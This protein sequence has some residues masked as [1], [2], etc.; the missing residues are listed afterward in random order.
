MIEVLFGESEAGAM[1]MAVRKYPGKLGKDVICLAFLLDIGNIQEAVDST[2]RKKLIFTL[3]N[4]EQWGKDSEMEASLQKAGNVYQK[5]LSRLKQYLQNGEPIRI[6]YSECPYSLCGFYQLCYSFQSYENKIFTVKLPEHIVK[7]NT[8]ITYRSWG[9]MDCN[10]LA[11]FLEFQKEQAAIERQ[12]YA[13]I[14]DMLV[15]DNS[16]LR[17]VINGRLTGV[18]E[19]F[20]DFLIW[21]HLTDKPVKEAQ[22]IGNLLGEYSLGIGDTWY[23]FRIEHFIQQGKVKVVKDSERKYERDICLA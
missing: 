7:Q 3:Y 19:S 9:E 5:E 15:K 2:Y 23:A 10:E 13:Y 8:V 14:W 11:G 16:P 6:W 21:K 1:R 20:Y 4:Q 17:A 12:K 18:A 22:L